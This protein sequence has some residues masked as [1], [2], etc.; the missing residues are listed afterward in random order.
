MTALFG[1]YDN[2]NAN[3]PARLISVLELADMAAN[4]STVKHPHIAAFAQHNGKGK[5]KDPS[6]AAQFAMIVMDHDDDDKNASEIR[7]LYDFLGVRYLAFTTS[8][9]MLSKNKLGKDVTPSNKWKV[10]VPLATAVDAQTFM[11]IS[12][13]AAQSLCTDLAQTSPTQIA[14]RPNKLSADA[15]YIAINELGDPSEWLKL[16]SDCEFLNQARIGWAE[17]E[18]QKQVEVKAPAKPRPNLLNATQSGIVEKILQAYS[19]AMSAVLQSHGYKGKG[20][21]LLSP[22]SSSGAAGVR[23][24]ERDGKEIVY[25]HHSESDPLSNHNHNGHALDIAD[26]FCVLD[27]GGDYSKMIAHFAKELDGEANKQRQIEHAKELEAEKTRAMFTADE[28]ETLSSNA[29]SNTPAPANMDGNSEF[30]L[31]PLPDELK[32]LPAGLGDIQA[33]IYGTMTYPCLYTAGWAAIATFTAFA[34]SNVTIDSRQGLGLNEF[35][36][37]LAKTG[38]GKESLRYPL[39][40]LAELVEFDFEDTN[41]AAA[42]LPNIE[43]AAPSSKQGL[44][45]LLENN[46]SVYIQSDEFAEWLKHSVSDV[47]KAQALAYAMEIYNRAL[48]K[49]HPGGAV[50][51]K[52]ETV[53][54]PRLSVFATTTAESVLNSMTREH[55]EMGAYN[56]FLIYVAPEQM[57][58]K[59]YTGL[60]FEPSQAAIDAALYVAKLKPTKLTMTKAGF[61]VFVEYD[62]T[63][64]EPIKFADGLMGGRLSE[65]AI[66]MAGLF[67]LADK[68]TEIDAN[69]MKLAYQIRLGLYHRAS[70]M[71]EQSGAI[72]G[73][74]ESAKALDQVKEL[75]QRNGNNGKATYISQLDKR[76]RAYAKLH[77]N[78]KQSVIRILIDMG[79]IAYHPENRKL[80]VAIK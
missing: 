60:V 32:S 5:T 4:P 1:Y 31:P 43:N 72:S 34:Q 57:P 71:V 44:H 9:H 51:N 68:R 53:S 12:K 52:Y 55:A 21:N 15:P 79:E 65:Q 30:N 36:L 63:Y 41:P 7:Q 16:D 47:H 75:V 26:V 42:N 17:R 69:D 10:V 80:L 39:H 6:E 76:S 70:A 19:G 33:Y 66:K 24:L 73:A 58:E 35:Y 2:H 28:L 54:N 3:T 23:I 74:H 29:A 18:R 8:S 11:Q 46:A 45:Q 40:K 22:Y 64:A 25:S 48:G 37:T 14:Y 20:L 62:K 56:R 50:T 13:G 38:F 27:F 59:K 78:E 67:A 77:I 61:A 49:I